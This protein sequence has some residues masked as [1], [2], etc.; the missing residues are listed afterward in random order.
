MGIVT[1]D[2]KYYL[3]IADAIREKTKSDVLYL[4]SEM[5]PAILTISGGGDGWRN[6]YIYCICPLNSTVSAEVNGEELPVFFDKR[7][8]DTEIHIVVVEEKYFDNIPII[9]TCKNNGNAIIDSANFDQPK[10]VKLSFI[11]YYLYDYGNEHIVRTGGFEFIQKRINYADA[12][13][14]KTSTCLEY[15]GIHF[16]GSGGSYDDYIKPINDMGNILRQFTKVKI[17]FEGNLYYRKAAIA[18]NNIVTDAYYAPSY[19]WVY[20]SSAPD[21][22][23]RILDYTP[24]QVVS[25][26]SNL[27]LN[28]FDDRANR[29]WCRIYS[30]ELIP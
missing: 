27:F 15:N 12:S 20:T 8:A 21:I 2:D 23:Y 29:P 4:P 17:A 19:D 14:S 24:S 3:D 13:F 1:T 16:D 26:D 25:D 6:S 10:I 5:A 22:E 30:I 7:E 18:I 11:S 28:I 9:V